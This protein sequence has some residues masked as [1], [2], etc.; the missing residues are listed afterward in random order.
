MAAP[1]IKASKGHSLLEKWALQTSAKSPEADLPERLLES[2]DYTQV[3][4]QPPLKGKGGPQEALESG[5]QGLLSGP[6]RLTSLLPGRRSL[7]SKAPRTL[8]PLW[9]L[10]K[11]QQLHGRWEVGLPPEADSASLQEREML[12]RTRDT[13][14]GLWQRG[15]PDLRVGCCQQGCPA[16]RVPWL[17]HGIS[18]WGLWGVETSILKLKPG[19]FYVP[20]SGVRPL[21]TPCLAPQALV[22]LLPWPGPGLWGSQG[23]SS[24]TDEDPVGPDLGFT[25]AEPS[26]SE[27]GLAR[28]WA[29]AN[30][31]RSFLGQG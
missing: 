23:S 12:R 16:A 24:R 14:G 10:L 18:P 3:T 28:R 20:T 27:P 6:W 4:G 29:A 26:F 15:Q 1:F 21:R 31:P 11:V 7:P 19:L 5:R 30:A 22:L 25:K 9:H 2:I 17:W 13:A 8:L